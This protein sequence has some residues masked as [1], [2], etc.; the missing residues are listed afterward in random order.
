MPPLFYAGCHDFVFWEIGPQSIHLWMEEPRFP[1]GFRP[2]P[3]L[4]PVFQ[5]GDGAIAQFRGSRHRVE[6]RIH[7]ARPTEA[8]QNLSARAATYGVADQLHRPLQRRLPATNSAAR[9]A[10]SHGFLIHDE[11]FQIGFTS[12]TCQESFKSILTGDYALY[13][14]CLCLGLYFTDEMSH[15]FTDWSC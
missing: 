12:H 1:A 3:S 13:A 6:S 2:T 14:G 9:P 5:V 8:Q 11:C 4:R 7:P 10:T 15:G